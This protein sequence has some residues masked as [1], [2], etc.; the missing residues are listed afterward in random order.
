ML[1]LRKAK[2][3]G[4]TRKTSRLG[5][6]KLEAREV[7]YAAS[8]NLWINPQLVTIGFVPDGTVI[9]SDASGPILSNLQSTFDNHANAAFRSGW[10]NE[11]LRA[12]QVWAQQT[13]IN[14]KLITDNGGEIGSGD[15]QQ[16]DPNMADIR[17]GGY[18]FGSA[19]VAQ[20]YAPPSV[21][22]YSIAGDMQFNLGKTWAIGA[23]V[24]S[25]DLFTVS[26]HEF[27]HSLGL[28]HST[29]S[30]AVMF[31][32]YN[33]VK[34]V[35]NADDTAGIRNIYSGNAARANDTW[36]AT[37]NSTVATADDLTGQLNATTKAAAVENLQLITSD[38]DY[39]KVTAP[40]GTASTLKVKLQTDGLSLLRPK[41][42]VFA[43]NG[44]TL[45]G[46]AT[47]AAGDYDGSTLSVN[48]TGVTAG[49]VYVLKVSGAETGTGSWQ[50][51]N[52]GRY[53]LTLNFGTGADPAVSLPDTTELNGNPIQGGGGQAMLLTDEFTVNG[54]TA[55]T[56][57][58]ASENRS[59]VAMD[60]NGNSVVVWSS[61]GQDGSGFGVYA[62]RYNSVGA[63]IGPEFQVNTTT[64]GDQRYAVVDM[65]D[66]GAFVVA[67][68]GPDGN[69]TGV[70]ARR[71]D[72]AGN[73]VG[74]EFRVNTYTTNTQSHPV[75][76]I[77]QAGCFVVGWN[78]YGQDG[79]G[80]GVYAQRY[81]SD[82]T[83]NGSEFRVANT[84]S[85]DQRRPSVVI[86]QLGTIVFTWSSNG[87]DGSGYGV[88]ARA[89]DWL[90]LTS[91]TEFRVSAM[92][93]GNQDFSAIAV[94]LRG[95]Y[96]IAWSS[97]GQDGSGHGIYAQRYNSS[98]VAA[99]SEF[100]VNTTTAGNQYN[101]AVAMDNDANIFI[102]WQ[103]DTA[104]DNDNPNWDIFGQ[105]FTAG[106]A[107]QGVEF[108]I[109]TTTA[110]NQYNASVAIAASGHA[111]VVW[112]GQGADDS[113]VFAKVY[114]VNA[115][116]GLSNLE[117]GVPHGYGPDGCGC[118][119]HADHSHRE[120]E[121]DDGC[122]CATCSTAVALIQPAAGQVRQ[123]TG[124]EGGLGQILHALLAPPAGASRAVTT[125]EGL[126]FERDPVSGPDA[127]TSPAPGAPETSGA[128]KTSGQRA[129]AVGDRFCI[130]APAFGFACQWLSAFTH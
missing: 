123:G 85:G 30:A 96:V 31:G 110:G 112:S 6:E 114:R 72:S 115:G 87:Q 42:E 100:R 103:S 46:S 119:D 12:A 97:E 27:G 55:N 128:A 59:A 69:G 18:D 56:Q 13:N 14:F 58:T 93:A 43:S 8:G 60:A 64:S 22:N 63:P 28:Y 107:I 81:W 9:G 21:N 1:W 38:V 73:A 23:G 111:M 78:S 130:S 66:S 57:E 34:S 109:N 84:T 124:A 83:K 16:G 98:L 67:W 95:D 19:T 116:N 82:G 4:G 54:T 117:A 52:T 7:L 99:D 25:Y 113:G 36:D 126:R 71:F 121:G 2:S 79:S 70:F 65:N 11:I 48:L 26:M 15:Y 17:I 129:R 105:Q 20:A 77:N 118:D 44:T 33:G 62:R 40:S 50:A 45:L 108:R 106:G 24:G 32:T 53:A 47:A 86:N 88:Y 37:S 3:T 122:G 49:T 74:D 92:T 120:A 35:L 76:G 101:P 29:T 39:Y 5:V 75:V 89:F 51:F 90:M 68:V 41:L 91:T 80:F 61:S 104:N 102:T 94:S 10:R 127:D 125:D